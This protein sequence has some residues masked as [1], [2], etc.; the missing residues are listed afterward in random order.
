MKNHKNCNKQDH[1]KWS[2]RS[3]LQ[4]LGLA[5]VG[6]MALA[7]G[8]VNFLEN[9]Q[10]SQAI[11]EADND[12]IL[13]LVRLGG[14]NDGLN[15]VIPLNQYDLYA[16]YRP[17]VKKLPNE[18]WNLSDD[19]AMPNDMISLQQTWEEGEMK[20]VH[21]VGYASQS[22]SHFKG[23]DN[24]YRGD[25]NTDI[26]SGW[27]GR[28]LEDKFPNYTSDPLAYPAAIQFGATN[29]F[30]GDETEYNFVVETI[31]KLESI[32]DGGELYSLDGL[33]DCTYDDKL[34]YARAVTNTVNSYAEVIY[35]HYHNSTDFTEGAG[36]PDNDFSTKLNVISRLIKGGIGTKI[37]MVTLGGFDTHSDQLN[38]HSLLM[39]KLSETISYFHK[40]LNASGYGDKVLTMTFSEF[41]RRVR[42]NGTG[43]DHGVAAPI[44]FFGKG[45]NG[46]GFVGNHASLEEDQLYRNRDLQWQTDFRQVYATVLKE[47]LCVDTSTVD[48]VVLG[49]EYTALDLGFSC[50]SS[51]STP[52]FTSTQTAFTTNAIYDAG[53]TYI[54]LSNN[55]TQHVVINLFDLNG[56]NLGQ[57][58]NTLLTHG[59]HKF[60]IKESLNQNL[61][62]GFYIYRITTNSK[63]ISKKV[64][65]I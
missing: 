41:G 45:L 51:L 27:M 5:S 56:N 43:T 20:I 33:T 3:F 52:T 59:P 6:S 4:S 11:N 21:S 7:N 14:G 23:S 1:L 22:Q 57:I 61:D 26:N 10:L 44:L 12:R 48:A 49:Q 63:T 60:N 9:N 28:Y 40:D 50:N 29:V 18:L 8:K 25:T 19:Y 34:Y 47:W 15:T 55:N 30:S 37:F 38:R 64:M 53:Q 32:L 16:N 35:E 24:W 17:N 62:K 54:H 2:R 58:N 65:L 31:N 39:T 42:D 46:N 13:I 36:Y